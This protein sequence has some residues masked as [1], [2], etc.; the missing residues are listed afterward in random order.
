M[1]PYTQYVCEPPVN[2]K[3]YISESIVTECGYDN[4]RYTK[5]YFEEQLSTWDRLIMEIEYNPHKNT[6]RVKETYN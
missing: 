2:K 5:R 3:H 6:M 4:F 1:E